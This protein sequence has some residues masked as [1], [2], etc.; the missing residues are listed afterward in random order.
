MITTTTEPTTHHYAPATTRAVQG[1]QRDQIRDAYRAAGL[2]PPRLGRHMD[3]ALEALPT[4]EAVARELA[5]E[6][7]TVEPA[8]ADTW[9]KKAATR[10]ADA[11]A[12]DELR[13]AMKRYKTAADKAVRGDVLAQAAEDLAEPFA[14]TVATLTEATAQLPPDPFDL[15]AVVATDT[16][17]QMKAAADALARLARFG[18]IHPNP[19]TS[20]YSPTLDGLL[21]VV[22][23]VREVEPQKIESVSRQPANPEA[24]P[25]HE[26]RDAV[27]RFDRDAAQLGADV[28]LVRL[29]RGEYGPHVVLSLAGPRDMKGRRRRLDSAFR[30]ELVRVERRR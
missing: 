12:N 3:I 16:T 13:A 22:N 29:V 9:T 24:D 4:A 28:T 23:I 25:D 15:D 1:K 19:P 5:D 10:L 6:L 26:A 20:A 7:L 14:A 11:K 17:R 30:S 18:D 8:K 2:E 21:P 27:R